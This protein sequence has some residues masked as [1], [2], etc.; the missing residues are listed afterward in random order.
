MQKIENDIYVPET[1]SSE[2][3]QCSY[4]SGKY[5]GLYG[6]GKRGSSYVSS[7]NGPSYTSG[8]HTSSYC[9]GKL[10]SLNIFEP[11]KSKNNLNVQIPNLIITEDSDYVILDNYQS[12]E[13]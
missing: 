11:I 9:S 1:K 6:S 12:I 13:Q 4:S 7:T 3:D 10:F 5:T 2:K 8:M